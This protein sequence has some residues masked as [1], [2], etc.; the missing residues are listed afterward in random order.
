MTLSQRNRIIP[1]IYSMLL[2]D[3]AVQLITV[4]VHQPKVQTFKFILIHSSTENINM[5]RL[6]VISIFQANSIPMVWSV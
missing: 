1:I 2:S 5:N 4:D 3:Y 6:I